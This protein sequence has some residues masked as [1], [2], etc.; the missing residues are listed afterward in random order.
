MH[1]TIQIVNY[2]SRKNLRDCLGS[3]QKNFPDYKNL[4]IIII[5][6]DK[7]RLEDIQRDFGVELI[8]KNENIGF[9]RAQNLGLRAAKGEFVF[10]LNPDTELFP[11]TIEKILEVFSI[12]EK[13]GIV[14]PIHLKEKNIL[15]ESCFG[16]L[17]TPLSII[18]S[19][20]LQKKQSLPT[21]IFETDWVSG[22]AMMAR[23]ELLLEIGGFDE[24]Y[25]MYFEDVDLC[26]R[27]KEKGWKIMVHP[28]AKIFHKSGQSFSSYHK[29]KRHY[30]RSQ[31]YYVKKNFGRGWAWLVKILRLPFYIRN[32]YFSK[33]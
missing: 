3:V 19:K 25:F 22:G 8:E 2:N 9:G 23:K 21:N 11:L 10:F 33:Q 12:D 5:N 28:E 30:Y 31:I 4:Q 26:L 20:I 17:R 24:N 16:F 14:G 27:A 32:V 1:L 15:D 18:G 13:V 29:K 7:E 6:N